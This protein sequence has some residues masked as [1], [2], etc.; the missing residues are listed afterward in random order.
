MPSL[1]AS[2]DCSV[3]V[4]CVRRAGASFTQG[5]VDA[6]V[7]GGVPTPVYTIFPL[8]V[9]QRGDPRHNRDYLVSDWQVCL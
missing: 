9:C 1:C 4:Q 5:A 3:L 6:Q 7:T 8:T 2:T